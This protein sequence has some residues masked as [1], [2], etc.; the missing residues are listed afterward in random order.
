MCMEVSS[1]GYRDAWGSPR[2]WK[3]GEFPKLGVPLM[4][5]IGD[6]HRVAGLP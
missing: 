4:G 3:Y 6:G 1:R 2:T 5:L